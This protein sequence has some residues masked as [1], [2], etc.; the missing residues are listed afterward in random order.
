LPRD[1]VFAPKRAF[2][3]IA[4]APEWLPAYLVVIVLLLGSLAMQAPAFLHVLATTG[5]TA[6]ELA[7]PQTQR[8]VIVD[9]AIEQLVYPLFVIG[10]TSTTLTAA[11]RAK[12]KTTRLAVFAS[13]AANC[14]VPYGIGEFISGIAIRVRDPASFKDLHA[15]AV[16]LPLNLALFADP[17]NIR[18]VD[19][20]SR[21]GL[22]GVW[23]FTLLAFGIARFAGLRFE[24]ALLVAFALN[25]A[26]MAFL[27]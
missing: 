10:L 7:A 9:A 8:D 18:E 27:F 22:F 16:A 5:A 14:L 12:G 4:A 2:D 15:I 11:A 26:F 19:F 6:D 13:L 23:S 21:F 20:L 3:T 25:F 1:I 24:T 17:K